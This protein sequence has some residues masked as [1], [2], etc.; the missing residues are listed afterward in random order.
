MK[1][2]PEKSVDRRAAD[3]VFK[4]TVADPFCWCLK[5]SSDNDM[6]EVNFSTQLITLDRSVSRGLRALVSYAYATIWLLFSFS[7]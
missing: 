6:I 4:C 1:S 7:V 3:F 2:V 5:G